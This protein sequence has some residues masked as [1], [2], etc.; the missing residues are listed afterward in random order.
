MII[1]VHVS[2]HAWRLDFCPSDFHIYLELFQPLERYCTLNY[3][4]LQI[5]MYSSLFFVKV[6]ALKNY[7]QQSLMVTNSCSL[8]YLKNKYCKQ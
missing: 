3:K 7:D 2:T 5:Y 4:D 8:T 6:L 1:L